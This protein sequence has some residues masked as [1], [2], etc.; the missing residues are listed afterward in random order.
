MSNKR[1]SLTHFFHLQV[2][3]FRRFN[4]RI[5]SMR[6]NPYKGDYSFQERLTRHG[7]VVNDLCYTGDYYVLPLDKKLK[8]KTAIFNFVYIFLVMIMMMFA[9]SLNTTSSR[10]AWIVFPY[11]FTLLPIGYMLSGA[12]TYVKA[13]VRMQ[14]V[15][16]ELGIERMRR[17]AIGIIIMTAMDA[18]LDVIFL[19]THWKQ[20]I[21][22]RELLYL[23]SFVVIIVIIM[24]F[25]CFFNQYYS[26]FKLE[27]SNHQFEE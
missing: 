13:P 17:S 12:I 16:Y 3:I 10:T 26:N 7:R 18:I 27:P 5:L 2:D 15:Q 22:V 20:L 4:E 21:L 9:G 11:V 6:K 24:F 1:C 8:K 19:F 14:R 23:L 25:R